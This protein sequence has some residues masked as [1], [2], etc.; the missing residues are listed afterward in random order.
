MAKSWKA[1]VLQTRSLLLLKLFWLQVFVVF[2]KANLS[3]HKSLTM[4]LVIASKANGSCFK[5]LRCGRS[6]F[7]CTL[8]RV[9]LATTKVDYPGWAGSGLQG[10]PTPA[11]IEKE[12]TGQANSAQLC[13]RLP[14]RKTTTNTLKIHRSEENNPAIYCQQENSRDCSIAWL[15]LNFKLETSWVA[16]YILMSVCLWGIGNTWPNLHFFQY[17][18]AYKHFTDP[19]QYIKA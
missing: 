19:I 13:C 8:I 14:R 17:I 16:L 3:W 10:H 18:Q 2:E 1:V 9:L 12:Q 5:S 11:L 4:G 7:T 15:S 6:C